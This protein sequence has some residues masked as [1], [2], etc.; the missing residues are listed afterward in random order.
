MNQLQVNQKSV[1]N[2]IIKC[3]GIVEAYSANNTNTRKAPKLQTIASIQQKKRICLIC[4]KSFIQDTL[5]CVY[6]MHTCVHTH[7]FNFLVSI[8]LPKTGY[9][10]KS[11]IFKADTW[12]YSQA[13]VI[14]YLSCFFNVSTCKENEIW[15]ICTNSMKRIT[16]CSDFS[17]HL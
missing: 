2:H 7:T 8:L 15:I 9:Y 17:E 1:S 12:C 13:A 11:C 4:D 14:K 3:T 10:F 5:L 6:R 16:L